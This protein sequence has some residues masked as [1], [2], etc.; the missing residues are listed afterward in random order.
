MHIHLHVY[1]YV[2]ISCT[3]TPQTDALPHRYELVIV[4]MYVCLCVCVRAHVCAHK[5]H[6]CLALAGKDP[7]LQLKRR[8]RELIT[9]H[10]GSDF[11]GKFGN[12]L[13]DIVTFFFV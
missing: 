4:F 6:L 5:Y 11:G 8:A 10:D 13:A 2:H 1:T 7:T 12:D 9:T 3:S